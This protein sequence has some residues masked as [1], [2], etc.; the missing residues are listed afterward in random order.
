MLMRAKIH[1]ILVICATLFLICFPVLTGNSAGEFE[2]KRIGNIHPYADNAFRIHSSEAGSL[3]IR[4]HDNVCIYRT[5]KEEIPAGDTT[6]HWDGCGY[7]REK[8]Y[9]KSYTITAELI[10]VSGKTQTISFESPVE[11]AS[12]CLQYALPSSD[13]LYL[14]D[15]K[16]WFIEYRT[17]TKG[18][19]VIE[20]L[21]SS[22]KETIHTYTVATEGGKIGRKTFDE[23]MG[24]N[25]VPR[26]GKYILSIYEYSKPDE[27][28]ESVLNVMETTP[29][30]VPIEPTG[31]IM[32]DREMTESEIW[33]MMMK[34][35]VVINIDSFKHQDVY[36]E[37][38]PGSPSLGT[39]HG[40]SQGVKVIR[41]ED[42]WA[43][44]GAWNHEE[45]SYVE[46]WVPLS[47]LKVEE[48]RGEYGILIDKRKQTMDVYRNGT[49]IDTLL[50]STGRAEK[51]NLFQETSAGCFL[52]GYHRVNFSMNGKKYDYVIQYDG[53]NLLHQTPYDWG[54]YK[55]D[56]TMGRGYLGAKAS[57]ACIRIQPEPGSGGVNAYWL[58]THLPYHT[59]VMILD[60]Q[61]EHEAMTE[62]LKR[63]SKDD[64]DLSILHTDNGSYI[65]SD[66]QVVITFGGCLI[67]GG[68]KSFNNKSNSFAA[69]TK[70]KGYDQV[71]NGMKQL[72]SEDDLT[73]VNL[74]CNILKDNE[75]IPEGKGL[76]FGEAGTE[77]IFSG[78]SVE[79]VQLMSEKLDSYDDMLCCSTSEILEPYTDVLRSDSPVI[80]TLKG[81]VF[82][83]TGC[84][85]TEYLKDPSVIDRRIR[86]LKDVGCEKIILLF[87]WTEGH[88]NA[89][90]I[91]QE[92]MAHRGVRAGASLIIGSVPGIIQGIDYIEDVP[93]VYS[94]GD[95]LIGNT[96]VKP[97][98]QQGTL[99]RAVFSFDNDQEDTSIAVIPVMPFGN[100]DY[101]Q[102]E[103]RPS[104]DLSYEQAEKLIRY[105]WLDSTDAALNRV[106]FRFP[107]QSY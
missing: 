84:R 3:K 28:Y 13:I 48:P 100:S 65:S 107:D 98:A 68:S 20:V 33:E 9:E 54:Q 12:Q 73:C 75:E 90:S 64:V 6:I 87:S 22:T 40:Q 101:G 49:V 30:P 71:L 63:S 44:I 35:S 57:H 29:D 15:L 43:L 11:Y 52:T 39:L 105:V 103:Y 2:I 77:T 50:V 83:L 47:K 41:L 4:I 21:S 58:F 34:P 8:L 16:S 45:A 81:H 69:Y 51:N 24:K 18:K 23:L 82:G 26:T 1:H 76:Y 36:Q 93:V 89:H 80:Y 62:K 25:P 61:W 92:A 56:F 32:A 46:G 74:C 95:L 7:N 99:V 94:L 72:F 91:V 17:V 59:R 31:E 55:K 106:L 27:K 85:E 88:Q 104:A 19:V 66:K 86:E 53:G 60:D 96:S 37:P 70:N 67:P 78:V 14:D 38:D 79:L 10:S 5:I 42:E 102:N 97:K